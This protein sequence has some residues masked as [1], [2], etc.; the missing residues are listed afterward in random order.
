MDGE[1]VTG[2]LTRTDLLAAL[3]RRGEMTPVAEFVRLDFEQV[4]PGDML[5]AAFARLQACGCHI[6]PVVQEDRLV[7]LLTNENVGEF[8]MIQSARE[9]RNLRRNAV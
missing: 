6:F 5:E 4:H 8:L 7:G 1:R 9:L 2:I 3:S